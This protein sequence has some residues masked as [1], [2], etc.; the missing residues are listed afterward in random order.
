MVF[1]DCPHFDDFC[2]QFFYAEAHSV[3]LLLLHCKYLAS[4]CC[5]WFIAV[6]N[7]VELR[8]SVRHDWLGN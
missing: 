3:I 5:E 7:G 1:H 4:V 8:L 6:C 2:G